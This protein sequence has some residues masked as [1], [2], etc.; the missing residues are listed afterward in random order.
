MT[1]E[2]QNQLSAILETLQKG[3]EAGTDFA[4]Q[5]MPFVVEELLRW[6]FVM[7]T[8]GTGIGV[9]L[10]IV[11]ILSLVFAV[12]TEDPEDAAPT[13]GFALRFALFP[14][15][16]ILLVSG[17]TLLKIWL[18]PRIYLIEYISNLVS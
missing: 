9:L 7:H 3:V 8:I 11:F 6:K 10:F 1:P 4:I 17:T 18:A 12:K 5:E 16:F 13:V 15:L 2:L 14:S